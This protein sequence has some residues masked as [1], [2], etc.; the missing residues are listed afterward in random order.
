[1]SPH[2]SAASAEN[3]SV[4]AGNVASSKVAAIR[5]FQGRRRARSS[6]PTMMN[7]ATNTTNTAIPIRKGYSRRGDL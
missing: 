7:N 6:P 5:S 3:A 4:S 2:H 1:M